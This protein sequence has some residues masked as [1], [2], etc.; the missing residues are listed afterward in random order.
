MIKTLI[1]TLILLIALEVKLVAHGSPTEKTFTL[2][3]SIRAA[4]HN[5]HNLLF[6][7]RGGGWLRGEKVQPEGSVLIG[8]VSRAFQRIA[9]RSGAGIH[10]AEEAFRLTD[11]GVILCWAFLPD[12]ILRF[13]SDFVVNKTLRRK[14]PLAFDDTPYLAPISKLIC[15]IGQLG[16]LVYIGELFLVFLGGLGVPH[17]EDKPKLLAS[18]VFSVWFAQA[19]CTFTSYLLEQALKR[20]H[21]RNHGFLSSRKVIYDRFIDATIYLVVTLLFLDYNSIDVGV[22]L[23]SLL[24]LG[25]VSSVVVGLALKEPV[26]EI[27]QGTNLLLSDKFRTGETI[28]LGDGST[29]KVQDVRWTDLTL[30]GSDNSFL[31]LPHSQLAKSRIVNLSRM[32]HSQV[33]QEIKLPNKGHVKI[34]QLLQDIKREI[35]SA[36]PMLIDGDPSEPFRVHWT[37][38]DGE[39][40]VISIESHYRIPRLGDAYYENRQEVLTAISRAV[41]KYNA[42]NDDGSK[43]TKQNKKYGL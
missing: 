42:N 37:D 11:L 7:L 13:I 34:R 38:L 23:A 43:N 6:N 20:Y 29:G 12:I 25:G 40:A 33:S 1:N 9:S 36:C 15:Q 24:T 31:R 19:L 5:E 3:Q 21:P 2:I 26:T 30:Q 27:V 18:L 35:R 39:K 28:R 16:L 4:S 8:N 17:L 32:P 22:A 14:N 41:E 10:N